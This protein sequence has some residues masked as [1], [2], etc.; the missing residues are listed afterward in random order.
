[1]WT[2]YSDVDGALAWMDEVRRR[3][4]RVFE[5]MDTG[6]V[7]HDWP[8]VTTR[9]DG[10]AYSVRAFV[11]GLSDKDIKLM[12]NQDVLTLSG[13]RKVETPPGYSVHRQERP[14]VRF[15]RSFALP[16]KVDPEKITATV[17]HGVLEVTLQKAPES[18]PR[19]ITVTAR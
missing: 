3:M 10:T 12:L 9:D 15:S 4:D 13:E 2:R 16:G 14:S 18:Q 1:M 17:R 8:R 19:Q 11:P 6:E 7:D 5:G